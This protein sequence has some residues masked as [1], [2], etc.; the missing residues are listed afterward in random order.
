MNGPETHEESNFNGG[1]SDGPQFSDSGPNS[2]HRGH[3]RGQGDGG[4]SYRGRGAPFRGHG[5]SE[6][7]PM[8]ILG[9]GPLYARPHGTSEEARP[10]QDSTGQQRPISRTN[11]RDDIHR[12]MTPPHV[13]RGRGARTPPGS[14]PRRSEDE[15]W[16]GRQGTQR[17]MSP[18]RRGMGIG[19]RGNRG[20]PPHRREPRRFNSRSP[21]RGHRAP[22]SDDEDPPEACYAVSGDQEDFGYGTL[23]KKEE[24]EK[25][26]EKNTTIETGAG[27]RYDDGGFAEDAGGKYDDGGFEDRHDSRRDSGDEEDRLRRWG[28]HYDK[29]YYGPEGGRDNREV[30]YSSRESGGQFGRDYEL[31]RGNRPDRYYGP[32]TTEPRSRKK[33]GRVAETEDHYEGPTIFDRVYRKPRAE[34][35]AKRR[36]EKRKKKEERKE[37]GERGERGEE[38]KSNQSLSKDEMESQWR[39]YKEKTELRIRREKAKLDAYERK[40][41]ELT[42]RMN[43]E[44]IAPVNPNEYEAKKKRTKPR[45]SR[46][47][48]RSSRAS[49]R[50]SISP[51]KAYGGSRSHY[52]S[53]DEGGPGS[54][55]PPPPPPTTPP[56][57]GRPM[58]PVTPPPGSTLKPII[59]PPTGRPGNSSYDYDPYY[60]EFVSRTKTSGHT[61]EDKC[62]T[63]FDPY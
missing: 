63:E 38:K 52:P 14:P 27:G 29:R 50:T 12:P 60:D 15:A 8:P 24:D 25:K 2:S 18:P 62:E 48:K 33:S 51:P 57:V 16:K 35:E 45:S 41:R 32:E 36:E 13:Q 19:G 20:A 39:E 47:S 28:T 44:K 11:Q 54:S 56:R 43:D 42:T 37:R 9:S 53:S 7:P 3:F 55:P 30:A 34:A 1:N 46:S 10:W 31:S 59:T 61:P 5:H 49:S 6:G 58:T 40:M 22:P 23:E 4:P 26:K 21:R 17:R